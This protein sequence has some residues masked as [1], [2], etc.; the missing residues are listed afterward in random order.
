MLSF[1]NIT[2]L[3]GLLFAINY[4]VYR[5]RGRRNLNKRSI[6][7]INKM[8]LTKTGLA[9]FLFVIVVGV[10]GGLLAV[11]S[12]EFFSKLNF[13]S[14]W[15]CIEFCVWAMLFIFLTNIICTLAGFPFWSNINGDSKDE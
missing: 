7:Q 4:F 15:S 1:S 12:P 3:I 6:G 2:I 5:L 11:L 8:Q 10:I 14:D 9:A 13:G